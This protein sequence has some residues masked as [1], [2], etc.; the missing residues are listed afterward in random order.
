MVMKYP[1][2]SLPRF[3]HPFDGLVFIAMATFISVLIRRKE[4]ERDT[5]NFT[6]LKKVESQNTKNDQDLGLAR[7]VHRTLVPDSFSHERADIWVSYIPMNYV[8]GDYAKFLFL[9]DDRLLVF[10]SDVTGHGVAAALLVN[11]VHAEFERL[12][13]EEQKPEWLLRKLNHFISRDFE[14]TN[15]YLSA[16]CGLLDFKTHVFSYANY[17]HPSQYFFH[18]NGS[19]IE[20]LASQNTLL[21]ILP[22]GQHRQ[23]EVLFEPGD[24]LLLFTDGGD[25]GGGS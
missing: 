7:R 17:G 14:G 15:M 8:S 13:Q 19:N 22:D 25:R 5:H 11:R 24:R 23:G 2:E 4:I 20:H 21:G 9:D 18:L 6:L 16:F 1:V 10:I 3:H 12:V